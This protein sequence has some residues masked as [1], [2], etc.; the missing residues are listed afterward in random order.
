M[1]YASRVPLGYPER[2]ERADCWAR[3]ARAAD[4]VLAAFDGDVLFVGHGASCAGLAHHFAGPA[5]CPT[6]MLPLCGVTC[7]GSTNPG[8]PW[9][10]VT[11]PCARHTEGVTA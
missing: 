6:G 10:V 5:G 4:A 11:A 8:G 1:T 9:T 3:A 2:D 7:V